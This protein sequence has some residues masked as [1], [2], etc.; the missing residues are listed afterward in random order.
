MRFT[1]I[2]D[3][4][5]LVNDSDTAD[6]DDKMLALYVAAILLKDDAQKSQALDAA[7]RRYNVLKGNPKKTTSFQMFGIGE[8][9]I[10]RRP[11]VGRYEPPS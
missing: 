2:R 10:R 7:N 11:Y 8:P 1:G 4:R 3:L 9:Q 5:P 6:L